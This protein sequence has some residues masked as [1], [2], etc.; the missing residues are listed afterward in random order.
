MLG[1]AAAAVS[2]AA[3]ALRFQTL[4]QPGSWVREGGGFGGVFLLGWP[5][6]VLTSKPWHWTRG[7]AVEGLK[8]LASH[9]SPALAGA[10]APSLARRL[11]RSGAGPAVG[12]KTD[13]KKMC[14]EFGFYLQFL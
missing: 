4:A 5:M 6:R 10:M 8:K 9:C 11:W 13:S 12:K 1:L 14:K 2:S 3:A 7:A